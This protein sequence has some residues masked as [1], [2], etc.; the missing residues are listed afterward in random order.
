MPNIKFT[1]AELEFLVGQYELELIEAEKY[2]VEIKNILKK[3]GVVYHEVSEKQE[4][5]KKRGRGRPAKVA[6]K[7]TREPQPKKEVKEKKKGKRGRP[8]KK[9]SKASVKAVVKAEPKPTES[10]TTVA[11]A[12]V[13][14]AA[15]SMTKTQAHDFAA[16]KLKGLPEKVKKPKKRGR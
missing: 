3:L 10:K 15:A 13:K 6:V 1:E 7:E 5:T 9:G 2:I 14:K 16:T 12:E 11:K 4:K 8:K